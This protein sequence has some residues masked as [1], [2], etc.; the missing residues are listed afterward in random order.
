MSATRLTL[1]VVLPNRNHAALLP[2]ALDALARQQ[3]Q[4]DEILVIN[5]ASTDASAQVI[6]GFRE[7]LPQIRLLE[8][9]ERLGAVGSLNR[10]LREA[11]G[12]VVYFG[13][14]DDATDPGLFAALMAAL[15][16]HSE[17]ALACA[18]ARV[19]TDSGEFKGYRPISLPSTTGG[20]FSPADTSRLLGRMDHWI[21]SVVA[22]YRRAPLMAAG[23]FD[24]ALGAFCDSFL[25]RQ[26]ALRHGFVFIP[27]VLG[28]WYVQAESYSRATSRDTTA[29]HRLVGLARQRIEAAEGDGF[30]HGYGAVFD[31]R[32]RFAAARLALEDGK[33]DP[34][35]VVA[36]AGLP[37]LG[38]PA[39]RSALALPG[40]VGRLAALAILTLWL[41]PTSLVGLTMTALRRRAASAA[42]R[43]PG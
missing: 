32:A 4:A 14:A 27:A 42:D 43:G 19:I 9:P 1:T 23:G 13:A 5:D 8:N 2:R 3:R 30:P 6:L 17:A 33:P 38:G 36:L 15:E 37:G 11:T 7:R 16:A 18:E 20:Y 26:L 21:L 40:D 28:T 39:L 12:D 41:R 22:A 31:R 35:L 24:E 10:G 25:A 34:A 29:L